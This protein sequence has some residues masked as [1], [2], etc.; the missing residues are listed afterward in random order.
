MS[1]GI[2]NIRW[3]HGMSSMIHQTDMLAPR[4]A[5]EYYKTE[6]YKRELENETVPYVRGKLDRNGTGDRIFDACRAKEIDDGDALDQGIYR[7]IIFGALMMRAG[8]KIRDQDLQHLR[9]L[10]PQIHCST[11]YALPIFDMGFR[12]PGRAQFLAAL[13]HY[14]AGVARSF[15]EMRYVMFPTGGR[16]NFG[17]GS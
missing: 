9:E 8:A 1:V 5:R 13:D 7:T 6:E 2:K 4:E 16:V 17:S 15:A 12:S 14:Q 11:T 10:V 3:K